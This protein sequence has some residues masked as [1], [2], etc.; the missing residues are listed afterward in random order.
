MFIYTENNTESHRNTQ[1]IIYST[2]QTKNTTIPF[3]F[4]HFQKPILKH[5]ITNIPVL[6]W[7]AWHFFNCW[8]PHNRTS[9]RKRNMSN[10]NIYLKYHG[11]TMGDGTLVMVDT[12]AIIHRWWYPHPRSSLMDSHPQRTVK[13][14][15]LIADKNGS[16]RFQA[17]GGSW[18]HLVSVSEK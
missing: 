1:N 2:K 18:L 13:L 17:S 4:Q 16:V 8:G 5:K 3:I 14:R 10:C 7:F 15:L 9:F 12:N 6:C 11:M